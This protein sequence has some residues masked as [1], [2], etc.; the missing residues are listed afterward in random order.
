MLLVKWLRGPAA[1]STRHRPIVRTPLR[2]ETLEDRLAPASLSEAGGVIT[3]SLTS[4]N[5]TVSIFSKG[6]NV[7]HMSTSDAANGFVTSG[8]VAPSSFSTPS[9]STSGDLTVNPADTQISINDGGFFGGRIIFTNSGSTN[10]YAQRFSVNLPGGN[11]IDFFGTSTFNDSLTASTRGSLT[12][13]AGATVNVNGGATTTSTLQQSGGGGS[14]NINGTVTTNAAETVL[15]VTASRLINES[16]TGVFKTNAATTVNFAL[17]TGGSG[18]VLLNGG[19]NDFAGPV[20]I[21][22]PGGGSITTL[23]FR[24]TDPAAVLPNLIVAPTNYTLVTDNTSI[25]LA[26]GPNLP[27]TVNFSYSAGGDINQIAALSFPTATFTVLGNNS[28]LLNSI[29]AG[30]TIGTIS[31]NSLKADN[32]TQ[33]SFIDSGSGANIGTS[34]LGLGTFNI[35]TL[36]AGNIMQAGPIVEKIGAAGNTFTLDPTGS[37]TS[38]T[39][40]NAG[41]DF[42]G[43]IVLTGPA[44]FTTVDLANNSLLPRFPTRPASVNTLT[45]D[46]PSAPIN[47]P[48]LGNTITTLD[49]TAQGI[50]QQAGKTLILNTAT[51]AATF[52]AGSNPI[53][54]GNVNDFSSAAGFGIQVNNSGPNQV[55]INDVSALNFGVGSS[56]LGNGTLTV[57]AGGAITQSNPIRQTVNAGQTSF[58]AAAGNSITLNDPG[59]Q[60]RGI[61]D[62]FTSGAGSA[63]VTAA[64]SL[65]MGTCVIGTAGSTATL[66]LNAGGNLTQD[67]GTTLTVAGSST[68][69]AGGNITLDNNG[70]VFHG[71]PSASDFVSINGGNVTIRASGGPIN[72]GASNVTGA[73]IVRA[74][75]A[76]TQ[77]GP[78]T[79]PPTSSLFDAGTGAIT[80]TDPGNDFSG[81]TSASSN[82]TGT[83]IKGNTTSGNPT[84]SGLASVAGLSVGQTITGPGIPVGT[85]IIAIGATTI[86]L[87]QNATATATGVTLT[88]TAVVQLTS[89]VDLQVGRINLGTGPAIGANALVLTA[90]GNITEAAGANNGI[91]EAP[92][93]GAA[94]FIVQRGGNGLNEVQ[95]LAYTATTGTFGLVFDGQLTIPLPVNATASAVQAALQALPAIGAG[96][97]SVSGKAGKYLVK[98]QGALANTN[99]APISL[100]AAGSIV[101]NSNGNVSLN[102]PNNRWSG[103]VD[104][105][106][107]ASITGLTLTNV[108]SLNF[109]GTP[110]ITGTVN[111]TSGQDITIPNIAYTFTRFTASA[112]ETYVTQDI[113]TTTS[114]ISF[115]GVTDLGVK[116]TLLTLS[117]AR[118]INFTGD[119]NVDTTSGGLTLAPAS[120]RAVNLNQGTWSE[121]ASPL[122][123]NGGSGTSSSTVAFNIGNGASPASFYMISGT[124]SMPG[125]GNV[126]VAAFAT[127][128]VGDT[129]NTAT[130][131]TVTLNNGTGRLLFNAG[132]TLS[133]GLGA[134]N[135]K[136][137]D[138]N[139]NVTIN[140]L[141]RLTAYSGVAGAVASPVLTATN[142]T[143]T[144]FFA[145]TVD[146]V[147]INVPHVF[148]MGSDLVVPTYTANSVAVVQGGTVSA[149]GTVTGF[150]PDGD[151]FTI[152]ASTGAAA[153]LTTATD[154]N[155]FLD[156]VVRNAAGPVTLTITTSKNLGDG[157]TQLGG[158]AV[159]GPG[160]ATIVAANSDINLG[161]VDPF[162]DILVQG[163]L[164]ALTMRD[165]TG[166]TANFQDFIRAGG[167]GALSTTITGRR[168]DSVSISLPTVLKSLTLADYTNTVGVDTVTAESFGTIATKGIANTS[169]LGDFIVSRL[170][171]RNTLDASTPGLGTVS[172]AH[173][174]SGQFDIQKGVTSVTSKLASNFSLGLPGA[175]ND[176]NGDLMGS[177][178]TL[179]LGIVTNS[180]IESIGNVSSTTATSWVTGSLTAN[181]F[182]AIKITG[183]AALPASAGSDAIF[184]NFKGI[185]L[186]A[187]GNNAGIGLGTLSVAGDAG[188]ASAGDTFNICNGNVT[189]VT[190]GRQLLSSTLTAGVATPLGVIVNPVNSKVGTITAGLIGG[191]LGFTLNARLLTSMSAIGNAAAGIFGD[192]L[193]A[194]AIIQGSPV[195]TANYTGVGIG[196]VNA[197]HN[198]QNSSFTVVNGSMTTV[199][200]GYQM[201]SDDVL[202]LNNAGK[203][204]A[205]TAGAWNGQLGRGLVAQSLGSIT[206]KGV[207]Q[208]APTSPLLIGNLANVNILAFVNTGATVGIGTF[209]VSGS[210]TLP[211]NGFLRS[212]NGITTFTVGRDVTASAPATTNLISVRDPNTGRIGTI[213]VGRWNN[214]TASV[215]LVA[216]A[217][218]TMNVTGYTA[219]GIPGKVAGDF[220]ASN[221]D[222]LNNTKVDATSI[223]V[224]GTQ[225]VSNLLAPGGIGSLIVSNQLLG[226]VDADNPKGILGNIGTLQAGQIGVFGVSVP[227]AIPAA[228]RA[229]T[230]GTFKTVVNIPL[231]ADGSVNGSTVTATSNTALAGIGTVSI[232]S[233]LTNNFAGATSTFDVPRPITTF[234]VAEDIRNSSQIAAGYAGAS[235]IKTFNAGALTNSVLTA[236]SIATLNV[237]GKLPTV[238][239]VAVLPADVA[240]S[241]V[242]ALGNV[243]GVGL[244]AV[245]IKQ[246]VVNSDFNIAGGNVNS[247]TVGGIF[248]S[249]VMVG[250]H[251]AAYDNIVATTTP[252]NWDAP[253]PGV[254]SKLGSFKTTGLFSATDVLDTANFR[255]SFIVAQQLGTVLITG[256]DQNVPG[257]TATSGGSA[258]ATFGVAFRGSAGAGPMITVTFSNAGV[259]TT[260]TRTAPATPLSPPASTSP[261][262]AFEYVNLGG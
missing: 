99:V 171:N 222:L 97:V 125:A 105:T 146:A 77:V 28:I 249:H 187:T 124:I 255:D 122:S 7:Y 109:V 204:G 116:A 217:I 180:N 98:F 4:N 189:A 64:G 1:K 91:T 102:N 148:L 35:T 202:L 115:S 58:T 225:N 181:S 192:I 209:S 160:A 40:A 195:G 75:G 241:V 236:R 78:I 119:V 53:V 147:N 215:D 37:G 12:V 112:K 259:L 138:A 137:V 203:L 231:G 250:A 76:I 163:P 34:N 246:K 161:G 82:G 159:D 22:E 165:F 31:F 220:L 42:E 144:G 2:L 13:H 253:P 135:D 182:S 193:S 67:P 156:V 87:S 237:I 216:D 174:V 27:N 84:V 66:N 197:A 16:A 134:T 153:Q 257:A 170:T 139:G 240:N 145:L 63:S 61:V 107:A 30:N 72:L 208:A 247:F 73:L 185:T 206:I 121:G 117:S 245:T 132:S 100:V 194:S 239:N 164:V 6:A 262:S 9:G 44:T 86:T 179:N 90:G 89:A 39:L 223:A 214:A 200:V 178:T 176:P 70:N 233:F 251:R 242:T 88:A 252:T 51:S 212:D 126:N 219:P 131:D 128:E 224:A 8:L 47:L 33:V 158:I 261:A 108:S 143:V 235:S 101:L 254:T 133:V 150:E 213:T 118:D 45:L 142:G 11:G 155:G 83:S 81:V 140:P 104:L 136:L 226:R 244:G 57:T 26:N 184:G 228:L 24:N 129:T 177:V 166:A 62:L 65:N 41:N 201:T 38:I 15:N 183:N 36:G 10:A 173:Q 229:V 114:S 190:V 43:P 211:N 196:T 103:L 93:A 68:L 106:T 56:N 80:L 50:F 232:A 186:T 207:P 69:T 54:L 71:V 59:N 79:G 260:Q 149:S 74:D 3:L 52:N 238:T 92:L 60:L 110:A 20:N 141:S 14:V 96:N 5:E 258:A 205:L 123:I 221:F 191:T 95:A 25:P 48:S 234:T 55:V 210:Y 198:L 19:P 111:L 21:N 127:F 29:P 243:A 230:F 167:T 94:A 130:V 227:A 17:T 23:S 46:Y 32:T 85:T 157:L 162:A 154:V 248:G 18:K 172:I 175:A 256:L 188:T 152:T 168:F 169:V 113:T 49:V 151:K 120:G 218:G 199:A